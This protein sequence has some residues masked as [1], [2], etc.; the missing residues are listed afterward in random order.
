MWGRWLVA[1]V[2]GMMWEPTPN[3]GERA[4]RMR[5]FFVP[6]YLSHWQAAV[7][8]RW[9]M[10]RSRASLTPRCKLLKPIAAGMSAG[11]TATQRFNSRTPRKPGMATGFCGLSRSTTGPKGSFQPTGRFY[12]RGRVGRQQIT[13]LSADVCEPQSCQRRIAVIS[14]LA[15]FGL[16]RGRAAG[17]VEL[18]LEFTANALSSP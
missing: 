14:A 10:P 8:L 3:S 13:Q 1:N 9:T 6:Y 2:H 5:L 12:G 18:L 16:W 17:G 15:D 7:S 11:A 4:M